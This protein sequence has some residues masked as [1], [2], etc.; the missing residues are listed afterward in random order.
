MSWSVICERKQMR[1]IQFLASVDNHI[2]GLVFIDDAT[3]EEHLAVL[4][5]DP[6]RRE[7]EGFLREVGLESSVQLGCSIGL[8]LGSVCNETDEC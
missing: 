5:N 3:L 2:L 6:D 1:A 8:Q 7:R 4:T